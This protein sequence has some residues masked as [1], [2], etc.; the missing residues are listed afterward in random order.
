MIILV[1]GTVNEVRYKIVCV[2]TKCTL[3]VDGALDRCN[4]SLVIFFEFFSGNRA[5]LFRYICVSLYWCSEMGVE[6]SN[7][8]NSFVISEFD[9]S[10]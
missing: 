8:L 9:C 10:G 5:F 2:I 6:K 7:L 3:S 1:Q 4:E